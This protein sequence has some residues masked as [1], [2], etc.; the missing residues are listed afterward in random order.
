MK[1]SVLSVAISMALAG[2]A[3][4]NTF[5]NGG[6]ENGDLSGWSQGGGCWGAGTF[7][8]PPS[9]G[10]VQAPPNVPYTGA[11]LPLDPAQFTGTPNNTIMTVGLD[12]ITGAQRVFNGSYSV[13]VNDSINNYGVS[14]LKQSVTSYTDNFLYFAWNAVLESS[15]GLTDS[16][17]FALTLRD[18]TTG[19]DIVT[20]AY[21]SAG[22]IGS[23]T[24]GVTWTNFSGWYSSGW[25]T[26]TIDLASLGA[27]GHDL[28]LL[29]MASDCPYG[30][31]A[32]YVYLDGFGGTPPRPTPEPASMALMGLG[33]AG[34]IAARR[35]KTA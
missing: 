26:E 9:W 27:V 25:V 5:V 35:R 31:H 23:G 13:R 17:Y 22:S 15:H 11:A 8:T 20:R 14:V 34:L 33:L 32:G 21:S 12:P 2:S 7:G 6:F 10:C 29:L 28:T 3:Y 4:A 16:D 24:T 1:K 19:N 30:G 18:D